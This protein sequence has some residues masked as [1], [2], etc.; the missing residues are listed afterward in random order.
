[1]EVK[2]LADCAFQPVVYHPLTSVFKDHLVN[3]LLGY[4]MLGKFL[5]I[6]THL[7]QTLLNNCLLNL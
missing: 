4:H 1:M 3:L 6:L 7:R 2:G 5:M